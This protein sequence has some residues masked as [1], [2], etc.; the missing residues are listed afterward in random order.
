[1]SAKQPS[2]SIGS[3]FSLSPKTYLQEHSHRCLIDLQNAGCCNLFQA[4]ARFLYHLYRLL[5]PYGDRLSAV[6][7]SA[8]PD[9]FPQR[10]QS[11]SVSNWDIP[12]PAPSPNTR[13]HT[14][15]RLE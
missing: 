6:L 5:P 3:F 15:T 13:T 12:L 9:P 8:R 11:S 14:H 7:E 1:M 4:L 2:L 10:T